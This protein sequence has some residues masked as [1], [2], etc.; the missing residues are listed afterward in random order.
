MTPCIVSIITLYEQRARTYL[1]TCQVQ[2]E[3]LRWRKRVTPCIYIHSSDTLHPLT[4][5]DVLNHKP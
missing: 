4:S 3:V 1:N 5:S 2:T